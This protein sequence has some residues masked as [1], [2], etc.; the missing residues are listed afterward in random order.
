MKEEFRDEWCTPVMV[1]SELKSYC[2]SVGKPLL[3]DLWCNEE[4][5]QCKHARTYVMRKSISDAVGEVVTREDKQHFSTFSNPPY[6]KASNGLADSVNGIIECLGKY[7]DVDHYIL[8]P[9]RTSAAWFCKCLVHGAN[10]YFFRSRICF[11]PPIG[12]SS[13]RNNRPREN[14]VLIHLSGCTAHQQTSKA[15]AVASYTLCSDMEMAYEISV[16]EV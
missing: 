9:S 11:E 5:A 8:A 2:G 15:F 6:S 3:L 7:P 10:F 16:G 14:S 1:I 12:H 13:L 4:N